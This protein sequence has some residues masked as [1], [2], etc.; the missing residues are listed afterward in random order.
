MDNGKWYKRETILQDWY[1]RETILQDNQRTY[2][3]AGTEGLGKA[4]MGAEFNIS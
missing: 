4:K 2:W 3:A 1:K